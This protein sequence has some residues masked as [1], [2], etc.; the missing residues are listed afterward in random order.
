MVSGWGWRSFPEPG[1]KVVLDIM[2]WAEGLCHALQPAK[3]WDP[4][5]LAP[6]V[7]GACMCGGPGPNLV[8]WLPVGTCFIPACS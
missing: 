2:S 6:H 7:L 8:P 3:P 1:S 5:S 4:V